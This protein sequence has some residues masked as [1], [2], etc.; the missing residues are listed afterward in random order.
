MTTAI[1]RAA[2]PAEAHRALN[3]H[4]RERRGGGTA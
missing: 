4:R 3:Q 2:T 1:P